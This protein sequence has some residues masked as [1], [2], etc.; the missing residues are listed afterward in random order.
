MNAA[1]HNPPDVS[2]HGSVPCELLHVTT[3]DD[4]NCDGR[5]SGRGEVG[6]IIRRVEATGSTNA[7]LGRMANEDP[8]LP[9]GFVLVAD[10]QTAGKGRQGRSWASPPLSGLTF[11][12]L[13]KPDVPPL[14]ASTL[15]LVIGLSVARAVARLL[16]ECRSGGPDDAGPSHALRRRHTIGLKWPNDI[17]IDGRKL[18]GILCEMR[19]EGDRVRHIVAGIGINVNLSVT[20]MPPEIAAM[21]TSLSIAAGHS[22]D[23]EEVLNAILL[24]LEETYL[25]W[26]T[27]G[28]DSLRQEI[29][30]FDI[31]RGN[32]VTIERGANT[33]SG[34]ASGIA[35]DGA[36]MVLKSDGTTEP[37]YSG[38]AHIVSH[39]NSD[40][41]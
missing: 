41:P 4:V 16:A 8:S 18:C 9:D 7:D 10:V 40:L 27:Q 13:L 12:V 1:H 37:V 39:R 32:P 15:P 36:L 23:R 25:R 24:S 14:R 17:Q 33:L 3:F 2:T 11:S 35:P 19:A 34:M 30:K 28:F 38:D 31:L 5:S 20:D 22:F 6:R 29:S 21:A 26:L